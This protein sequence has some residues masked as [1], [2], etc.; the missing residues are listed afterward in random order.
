MTS[1]TD[2]TDIL[3]VISVLKILKADRLMTW[4]TEAL[5]LP[6]S[7]LEDPCRHWLALG[8]AER[9]LQLQPL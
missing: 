5:E 9:L 8:L 1:A 6:S 2:L 4:N 3:T 7:F